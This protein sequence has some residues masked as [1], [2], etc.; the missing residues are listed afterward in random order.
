MNEEWQKGIKELKEIKLTKE[1]KEYILKR[2]LT[3]SPY[4]F[5]RSVFMRRYAGVFVLTIFI[6]SGA[7]ATRAEKSLP[8][9]ALYAVKI[10]VTEP[11][12][13]LIKILPEEKMEWEAEKALRRVEEAEI[14]IA[15]QRLDDKKESKLNNLFEK[16]TETIKK[17]TEKEIKKM[18]I[19]YEERQKEEKKT[20]ERLE[21]K[22]ENEE[23]KVKIEKE[24]QTEEIKREE[25]RREERN[26]ELVEK[27]KKVDQKREE[28]LK[29]LEEKRQKAL[30]KAKESK[31]KFKTNLR[32][33]RD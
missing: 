31:E 7:V 11:A 20:E 16:H 10:N 14:L 4:V 9:D 2:V 24:K 1:E 15:E 17:E 33:D 23:D 3:R 5:R 30:E 27:I 32:E 25:E 29:E 8:G 19:E 12:R 26:K 28:R 18:E 6:L 22:K 13:D 21:R